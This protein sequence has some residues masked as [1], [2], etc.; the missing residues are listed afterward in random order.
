MVSRVDGFTAGSVDAIRTGGW[1]YSRFGDAIRTGGRG[2][3]QLS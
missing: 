3:F 2:Y 1:R